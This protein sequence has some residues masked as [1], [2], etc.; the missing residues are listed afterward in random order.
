MDLEYSFNLYSSRSMWELSMSAERWGM[1]ETQATVRSEA[2]MTGF[3]VEGV[4]DGCRGEKGA[5]GVSLPTLL[6]STSPIPSSAHNNPQGN[7]GHCCR[8]SAW[9]REVLPQT[10]L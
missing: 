2:G 6:Q 1:L 8:C 10:L 9:E 3:S 4:C 5:Q 7:S